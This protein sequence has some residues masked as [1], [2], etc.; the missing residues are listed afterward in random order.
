[1]AKF[2]DSELAI[3][4]QIDLSFWRLDCLSLCDGR[5]KARLIPFNNSYDFNQF[6]YGSLGKTFHVGKDVYTISDI[7]Y[8]VEAGSCDYNAQSFEIVAYKRDEWEPLTNRRLRRY[9]GKE[10][11]V[12]K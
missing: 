5:M 9:D 8:S 4:S 2:S 12:G 1:M 10:L 11:P 3:S 7:F 6:F